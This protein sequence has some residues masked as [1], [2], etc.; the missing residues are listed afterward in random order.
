MV[1]LAELLDPVI[2]SDAVKTPLGTVKVMVVP[3]G[4]VMI[5]AVTP[6]VPPVMVS[7]TEKLPESPT[8][9]VMVPIG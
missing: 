5:L 1:V 3:D 4:L 9:A 8:V 7:P 6:L 2:V